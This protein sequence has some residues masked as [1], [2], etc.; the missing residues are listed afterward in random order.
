MNYASSPK[1]SAKKGKSFIKKY[2]DYF[3]FHKQNFGTFEIY[4]NSIHYS[5]VEKFTDNVKLSICLNQP[6]A[7]HAYLNDFLLCIAQHFII[8]I[9]H[10]FYWAN[11]VQEN[12]R[13]YSTC[14]SMRSL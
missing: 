9:A 5:L 2:D 14:L 10:T 6:M 1:K 4:K 11:L 7:C 8:K 13:Y 3:V 12:L